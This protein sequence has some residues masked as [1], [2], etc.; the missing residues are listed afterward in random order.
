VEMSLFFRAVVSVCRSSNPMR[1]CQPEFEPG[2]TLLPVRHHTV[3]KS[4]EGGAMVIV[5]HVAQ[6][7]R[8]HVIDGAARP[9]GT[10]GVF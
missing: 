6:L 7:M 5:L 9:R 2:L 8:D 3:E 1:S 4:E 10:L